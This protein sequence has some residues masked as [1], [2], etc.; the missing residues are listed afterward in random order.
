MIAV[1][2]VILLQNNLLL[3]E[4]RKKIAYRRRKVPLQTLIKLEIK[5]MFELTLLRIV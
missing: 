3:K 5:K 2:L 4:E 1:I